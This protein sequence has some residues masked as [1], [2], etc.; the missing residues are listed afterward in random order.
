M[1]G[2]TAAHNEVRAM[3]DTD[4]PL[5]PLTWSPEIAEF[6][7]QWA[8]ML[9]TQCSIMHRD[10]NAYGE[11]IAMYGS[12]PFPPDSTPQDAVMGWAAEV[13]CWSYGTIDGSE[14][15]DASCIAD[16]NSTGCGHYTQ[17]VWRNSR[18]VGCGVSTCS[19]SGYQWDIWV[20]NYDP[21]G[22]YMGQYPY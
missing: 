1:V 19:G 7:Q 20:C 8:D 15:C 6:A 22:N 12:A 4:P 18:E 5:E 14:M 2:M 17:L 13:S 11:N 9:A 16:L 21:P 3:L 10:P